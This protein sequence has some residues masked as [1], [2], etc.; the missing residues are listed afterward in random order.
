MRFGGLLSACICFIKNILI[1]FRKTDIRISGSYVAQNVSLRGSSMS[2]WSSCV[3]VPV[4]QRNLMFCCIV[5]WYTTKQG[6]VTVTPTLS[7]LTL[8]TSFFFLD[9][10]YTGETVCLRYNHQKTENKTSITKRIWAKEKTKC[11]SLL[12]SVLLILL[13]KINIFYLWYSLF[14]SYQQ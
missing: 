6:H 5:I 13:A 14:I 8:K 1:V 12:Y 10:R 11:T 3:C 7:Y 9:L 4:S 2:S